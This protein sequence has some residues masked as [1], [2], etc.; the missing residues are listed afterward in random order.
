MKPNDAW[1]TTLFTYIWVL[2]VGRGLSIFVRFPNNVG[3][4][5]DLGCGDGFSPV[6]LFCDEFHKRLTKYKEKRLAQLL[7]SHPHADHISEVAEVNK[8]EELH[9]A[10]LTCPHDKTPEEAVDWD[11]LETEDNRELLKEYRN[12]YEKRNPPLQTLEGG[13]VPCGAPNVEYGLYY[14]R[15]P[16]VDEEHGS[17][18]QHYG[19]GLSFSMYVRHGVQSILLPGDVTPEVMKVLLPA[20]ESIE[21]RYS[22][23]SS[24]PAQ[25]PADWNLRTSTQPS[26]QSLLKTRGLTVLVPPHHGLESGYSEELMNSI[27]GGKPILNVISEKRHT[28]ENDGKVDAR[29]QSE[30]GALGTQ[31]D[32]E[33]KSEFCY[34]VSTRNGQHILVVLEGTK[35][36]P[37]VYL[38]E[39]VED[40]LNIR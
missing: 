15:P 27:K 2:N 31:V 17:S 5:Y 8:R 19:N 40:L 22:Y 20:K 33:G 30:S 7:M 4:I 14:M 39:D 26:L 37:R 9:A 3:L 10:L 28:G 35:V 16:K 38:R 32:I 13:I 12:T 23:L 11:R 25:V 34:S 1:T 29:Y 24:K 36:P 6:Q 21:K 18:D